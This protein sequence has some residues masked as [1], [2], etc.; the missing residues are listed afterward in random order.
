MQAILAATRNAAEN[1]D[2][3][4]SVGNVEV[5]KLADLILVAGDPIQDIGAVG[6][7]AFVA[8][9]GVVYR[10]DVTAGGDPA[11]RCG[12]VVGRVR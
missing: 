9:D 12:V 1:L 4:D 7:V 3:V 8:K 11:Y 2:V 10:N 5:G 6:Q